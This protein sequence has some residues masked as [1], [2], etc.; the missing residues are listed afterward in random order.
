MRTQEEIKA[1]HKRYIESKDDRHCLECGV[2]L[3]DSTGR[4]GAGGWVTGK[5]MYLC[6]SCSQPRGMEKM[7]FCFKRMTDEERVELKQIGVTGL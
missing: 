4:H 5:I 1:E 2:E 6:D 3:S 7:G